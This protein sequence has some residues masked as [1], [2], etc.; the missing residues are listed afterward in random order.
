M[1]TIEIKFNLDEKIHELII[2]ELDDLGGEGYVQEEGVLKAY[3]PEE[4]WGNHKKEYLAKLL[5]SM[6]VNNTWEEQLI[7]QQDWNEPWERSIQPI[8]VGDF[9]VRPSWAAAASEGSD[10]LI[11]II[12]DPKMS[13]GTGHHETTRL[14]LREL[15]EYLKEGDRVLDAGV[16]T[17]ILSIAAVKKGAQSVIG[18]DIDEWAI[19]N[20]VEN[21]HRNDVAHQLDLRQGSFD[22]VKED[23]FH[24]IL[25]NINLNVLLAH[26]S[27]FAD[28]LIE[29]GFL[30]L[31]GVLRQDELA[32]HDAFQQAGFKKLHTAFEGDWICCVLRKKGT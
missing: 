10:S 15:P 11:E 1:N 31:S 22:V 2:A 20:G 23:D 6:G 14:V 21:A 16:G 25:A 12:I 17:S 4:Q 19:T 30:I 24:V 3:M 13:F 18:F 27:F 5:L 32:I 26:T 28:K 9:Y 29:G 7:E 8:Q